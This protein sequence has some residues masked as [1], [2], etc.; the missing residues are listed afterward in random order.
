LRTTG[1]QFLIVVAIR[2]TDDEVLML[3]VQGGGSGI[4][5]QGR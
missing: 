3:G 4:Y 2:E 5:V 1:P